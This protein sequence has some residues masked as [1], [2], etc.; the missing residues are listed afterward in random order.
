MTINLAL[1][2]RGRGATQM[3]LHLGCVI[4]QSRSCM[5]GYGF[6]QTVASIEYGCESF[7][8]CQLNKEN[9]LP[10]SCSCLTGWSDVNNIVPVHCSGYLAVSRRQALQQVLDS[11]RVPLRDGIR[12][13]QYLSR[14]TAK[15]DRHKETLAN[16][17][18]FVKTL[19]MH[20]P[21]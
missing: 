8:P 3:S 6:H 19:S 7:L 15:G 1:G 17:I 12:V 18:A 21:H 2:G 16:G 13:P 20:A 9:Y 11:S 14:S 4:V 5:C 10:C